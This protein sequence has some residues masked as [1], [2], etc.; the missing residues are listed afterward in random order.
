M[1]SLKGLAELPPGRHDVVAGDGL[2]IAGGDLEGEALA[3][4]VA[5]ALPILAP[6][7]RHGLPP[8][9]RPFD[10]HRMHVSGP[11]NIGDENQVEV[12]VTI[13]SEPYPSLLRTG[14]PTR[15]ICMVRS[16]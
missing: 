9:L 11:S 6:V 1:A 16:S 7:S 10:G 8:G 14:D 5:I 12:R 3:V 4:E 2:P 13:D 15:Y